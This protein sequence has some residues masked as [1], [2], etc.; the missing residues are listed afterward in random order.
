MSRA[1][2]CEQCAVKIPNL[3]AESLISQQAK[4]CKDKDTRLICVMCFSLNGCKY[5]PAQDEPPL[6]DRVK[7]ELAHK[8]KKED[9][10]TKES[11]ILTKVKEVDI[12]RL[13]TDRAKRARYD[14]SKRGRL[15]RPN[16]LKVDGESLYEC[17]VC[18]NP[19]ARTGT[20]GKSLDDVT[21]HLLE[22]D[23]Y[24]SFEAKY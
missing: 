23:C 3:L 17:P 9:K 5:Y 24:T 13:P 20:I 22:S 7:A 6:S 8:P 4:L 11:Q 15:G 12:S 2:I 1:L 21:K 16:S 14:L 18:G 10:T 19:C